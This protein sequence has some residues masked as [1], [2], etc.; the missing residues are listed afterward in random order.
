MPYLTAGDPDLA[1]TAR[2]IEAVDQAGASVIEVGFPF[3]DPVA[4][5]PTIQASMTYA[6]DHGVRIAGIFDAVRTARSN[7]EAGLVAMVSFSMVHRYG[8]ERFVSDAA[9]AGFDGF[10]FPDLPIES[11][12]PVRQAVADAG[13]TLSMLIAPTTSDERARA[14][15]AASTGFVY[16]VSRSGITGEQAQL[17][18]ELP[19]RLKKLREATA[20]P[21][22]VGFG[23]A[24]AA[25][26]RQVVELAD[27]A[28]VGSALVRRVSQ[29]RQAGCEPLAAE[30]AAFVRELATG[31]EPAADSRIGA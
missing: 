4:D 15:A 20:L 31:L 21:L 9:A 30:A 14:I 1:T 22:A 10:I 12:G 19:E 24:E 3:S 6:L 2:L 28:I 16:V 18:A 27:A 5:G 25:Q 17:P 26:V 8:V 7:V 23:I 11:A 13:L 29:H